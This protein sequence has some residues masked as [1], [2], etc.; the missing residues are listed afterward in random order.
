MTWL[1]LEGKLVG[2][3]GRGA[4]V[5]QSMGPRNSTEHAGD[6]GIWSGPL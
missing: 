4:S 5:C 2:I 1:I 6:G 3:L